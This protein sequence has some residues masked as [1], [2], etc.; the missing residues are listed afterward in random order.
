MFWKLVWVG[1]TAVAVVFQVFRGVCSLIVP[2]N[3]ARSFRH[4]YY[5]D[6]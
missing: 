6:D 5:W 2:T 3:S 1:W 4:R